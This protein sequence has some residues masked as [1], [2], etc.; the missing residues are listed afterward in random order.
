MKIRFI[1]AVILVLLSFSTTS[2]SEEVIDTVIAVVGDDIILLSELQKQINSQMMARGLDMNSNRDI[3]LRL[4]DETLDGMIDDR[5]L[6]MKAEKDSLEVDERDV[7]RELKNSLA[8][9]RQRYG[10]DEAYEDGLQEYGLTEVQLRRMYSAAIRNNYLL[11]QLRMIMSRHIS[12]TPQDLEQW[13]VANRDSL[14]EIPERFK[15]SHI[16]LYPGLS[17]THKSDLT[18]KL[19]KI[20]ERALAGEDFAALAKEFSEDPG[21][22]SNGGFID[23]FNRNSGYNPE[24]TAAA[25]SLKKGEISNIVETIY[26]YHIIKSEDVKDDDI[27][28]RHILLMFDADQNNDQVLIDRLNKYRTNVVEDGELFENLAKKYS[29]D[30]TSRDLGGK[31]NWITSTQG[32]QDSG[33]PSFIAEAKKMEKGGVSGPFKS[34]YGYHIIQ[35][36]DFQEAHI[37][38]VVD[39]RTMIENVIRQQKFIDEYSKLLMELRKETYI[40]KRLH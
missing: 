25:F 24:F 17:D 10:N 35:L 33:I 30:E 7:D 3:L 39:D 9:L 15:L 34:Q 5:L 23:W 6:V 38:N 27:Q 36:D 21:T 37:L 16:L 14:P 8:E 11:E 19:T 26:G 20:R 13:E 32:T 4:R 28:A 22:A 12:V 1:F 31:I 2:S 40:D 18:E 29:E